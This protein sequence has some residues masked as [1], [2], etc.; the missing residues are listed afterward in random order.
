MPDHYETL[1][2]AREATPDQIKRAYRK[3]AKRAHPDRSGGHE[4][5]MSAINVAYEVLMN[6]TR[7]LRYDRTGQD[8]FGDIETTARNM[9]V[10]RFIAW[11]QTET[12]TQ[13]MIE[14]IRFGLE[15]EIGQLNAQREGIARIVKQAR[16]KL[17]KLKYKGKGA[18][19]LRIM[20]EYHISAFEKQGEQTQEKLDI[21][22]ATKILLD[23]YEFDAGIIQTATQPYFII[24]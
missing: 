7:R 13:G 14:E 5:A 10:G 16:H 17:T 18:D 20:L 23:Q 1:G 4:A 21:L 12:K 22:N 11:I 6:P 8:N 3:A 19:P 24:R 15:Q 2:V 9:L